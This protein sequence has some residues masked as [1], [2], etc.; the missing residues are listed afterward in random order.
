MGRVSFPEHFNHF[1]MFWRRR[2]V[3]PWD[4]REFTASPRLQPCSSSPTPIWD[5]KHHSKVAPHS[6]YLNGSSPYCFIS[7]ARAELWGFPVEKS[8]WSC[9]TGRAHVRGGFRMENVGFD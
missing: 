6:V 5:R 9:V 1:S 3:D 8:L 4:G 7:P 2:G